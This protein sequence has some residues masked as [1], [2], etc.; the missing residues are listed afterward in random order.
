MNTRQVA[1]TFL[2]GIF[3][4][5]VMAVFVMNVYA[6]Q[7]GGTHSLVNASM[8]DIED[9]ALKYTQTR[10]QVLSDNV[11]I[12]LARPVTKQELPLL[13]LPQIDF[14]GEDPPLA[15][16]VLKGE[17]DVRNLRRTIANGEA[18]R[19]RFIAYVFDLKAGLP[20]LTMVS[21]DGSMFRDLLN[22]PSLPTP[23]VDAIQIGEPENGVELPVP[24]APATKLPYGAMEPPVPTPSGAPPPT[25]P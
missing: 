13:G 20:T 3:V 24:I 2:I 9:A 18:W 1:K 7:Q 23:R 5:G 16:V 12:P 14:G 8:K 19:V 11:T 6:H 25:E 17:F 22:D 4:V 15:L 21:A 10:F